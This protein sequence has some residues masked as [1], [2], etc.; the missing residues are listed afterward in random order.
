MQTSRGQGM[1]T[2]ND[3]LLDLV[4]KKVIEPNEALSKSVARSEM[5]AMLER[6]GFKADAPGAATAQPRPRPLERRLR[7]RSEPSRAQAPQCAC[8]WALRCASRKNWVQE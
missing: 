5:R 8:W 2:L 3:S 1:V 4:K 6:A 7:P